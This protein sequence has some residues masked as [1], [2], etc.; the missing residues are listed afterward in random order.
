MS[1][2]GITAVQQIAYSVSDLGRAVAFYRDTL[3]LHFLFEAPPALAFFDCGGV[4][5]MLSAQ[6]GESAASHP[7]VYFG[8]PDIRAAVET[9][10]ERGA[11]VEGE[12]HRV[13][14]LGAVDL[15]LA[16]TRDPDGHVVGLMSEQPA[17]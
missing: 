17:A 8:V 13:A 14:R 11:P 6:P 2:P 4:R 12:P 7:I 1:A 9:L 15:W 10:R 5:L 3:G 16:F